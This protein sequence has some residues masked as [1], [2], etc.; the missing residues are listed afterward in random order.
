MK[1]AFLGLGVMGYPMAGHLVKKGGHT[2]TVWNRTRDKAEAWAKEYGGSAA[3]TAAEAAKG[4][5]IVFMCA[6][7]DPDVRAVAT[8]AFPG[9]TKGAVLVAHPTASAVVAREMEAAARDTGL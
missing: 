6:G 5:E 1:L 3:A 8:A 2:V 9:M 7:D 4:A